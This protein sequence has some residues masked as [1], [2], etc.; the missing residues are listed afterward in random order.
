[1]QR[2]SLKEAKVDQQTYIYYNNRVLQKNIAEYRRDGDFETVLRD[3]ELVAEEA[4][5]IPSRFALFS[6]SFL[7]LLYLIN[8]QVKVHP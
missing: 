3:Y 5:M 8:L 4:S 2:I 6:D 1:V 7:V